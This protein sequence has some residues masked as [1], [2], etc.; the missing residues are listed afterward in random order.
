[1]ETELSDAP[2][3][4]GVGTAP[5]AVR[6]AME[7]S[8]VVVAGRRMPAQEVP[9]PAQLLGNAGIALCP[10]RSFC[11]VLLVRSYLKEY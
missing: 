7:G 4:S 9:D 8:E 6:A 5:W 2:S 1:M 3:V 10:L 11:P